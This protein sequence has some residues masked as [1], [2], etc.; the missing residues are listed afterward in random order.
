MKAYAT[1]TDDD[2]CFYYMYMF[3][4]IV[5]LGK[6]SLNPLFWIVLEQIILR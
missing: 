1:E 2:E 3:L 4:S 6:Q 5:I